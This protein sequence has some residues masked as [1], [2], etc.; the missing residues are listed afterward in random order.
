M[1]VQ[2]CGW[3][4]LLRRGVEDRGE[5][6]Q[7]GGVRQ[8]LRH[9]LPPHGFWGQPTGD[10]ST[11]GDHGQGHLGAPPG[12]HTGSDVNDQLVRLRHGI[13]FY[14]PARPGA[15]GGGETRTGPAQPLDR[16]EP[17]SW[18]VTIGFPSH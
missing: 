11:T 1:E 10:D 2:M 9:P 17:V 4:V 15:S 5:L 7:S 6:A 16:S 8:H 13:G 12:L 14:A 3:A 18:L